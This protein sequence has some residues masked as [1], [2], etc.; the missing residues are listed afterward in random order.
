MQRRLS[1][2]R[3][4]AQL[5]RLK[6]A[7]QAYMRQHYE[8]AAVDCKKCPTQAACCT[9]AHFV[10]VHITRL[11]AAAIKQTLKRTPRL[12]DEQR[13]AVYDRAKQAIELYK[14]RRSGD[15]FK[16]TYSCPLFDREVGCLVHRR[17]KPAA[18]IQHACY[19]NW[20]DLPPDGLQN[21]T[22][23]RIEQL[24]QSVYGSN[25]TWLP[26]PVWLAMD[27]EPELSERAD[28]LV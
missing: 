12:N 13:T 20:Q 6:S 18:C 8:H 21:R 3:A 1:E 14:L 11:E 28:P 10:N 16:Q 4:I 7:Y 19:E 23:H 26:I 17:A 22:E 15:T 9:D 27:D 25:W 2:S 24:N 5:Q